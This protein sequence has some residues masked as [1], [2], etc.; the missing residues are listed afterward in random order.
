MT[1]YHGSSTASIEQLQPF[2]SNHDR[3][4]VYLTDC[5][6]LALFYAHNPIQRPGGFFPYWFDKEGR[7]QYDEYFP[8]QLRAMYEGHSGWVYHVESDGLPQLEK[9]P[10]VY[11]SETPVPVL[12]AEYVPDLYAALLQAESDGRLR[13]NRYED[14]PAAMQERHRQVVRRSLEGHAEDD[15]VRFLRQYMPEIF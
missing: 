1:L 13:L 9:M 10:W 15:Y 4:Y 12:H 8:D 14:I 2:S 7:L 6:T 3:A 11:L 5:A